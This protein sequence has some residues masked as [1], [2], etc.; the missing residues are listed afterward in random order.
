MLQLTI[1]FPQSRMQM[2]FEPFQLRLFR[3]DS[4]KLVLQAP[5]DLN[6]AFNVLIL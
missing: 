4:D 2:R 3:L 6:T 5:S 1:A